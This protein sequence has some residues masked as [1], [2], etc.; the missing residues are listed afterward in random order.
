MALPTGGNKPGEQADNQRNNQR[1]QGPQNNQPEDHYIQDNSASGSRDSGRDF[2]DFSN[3]FMNFEDDEDYGTLPNNQNQGQKIV[4]PSGPSGLPILPQVNQPTDSQ[5]KYDGTHNGTV[6]NR[7]DDEEVFHPVSQNEENSY[8]DYNNSNGFQD[9]SQYN[10]SSRSDYQNAV[11]QSGGDALPTSQ[12]R[13]RFNRPNNDPNAQIREQWNSPIQPVEPLRESS[14]SPIE[15]EEINFVNKKQKKLLPFGGSKSDKEKNQKYRKTKKNDNTSL[16]DSRIDRRTKAK[17]IRNLILIFCLLAVC[18]G[19]YNAFRPPKGVTQTDVDA[20]IS[21]ALVDSTFP[22][23]R[24]KAFAEDFMAA[25]LSISPGA[26]ASG[27]DPILNYYYTGSLSNDAAQSTTQLKQV[28]GNF[29]QTV[30]VPPKVFKVVPVEQN[31]A[32]FE[33]GAVVQSSNGQQTPDGTT[34]QKWVFYSVNVYYNPKADSL[35]VT[36]DS[37]ILIPNFKTGVSVDI[38]E[39]KLPGTGTEDQALKSEISPTINAFMEEFGKSSPDSHAGLD[40]YLIKGAK[41]GAEL[42]KG[43][44]G[45][46]VLAGAPG[47]AV[48][49][50]AYRLTE[51]STTEAA[52]DVNVKWQDASSVQGAGVVYQS[53][54]YVV[55]EKQPNGQWLV[56][57]MTPKHYLKAPKN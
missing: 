16:V 12:T 47:D 25:Y 51:K 2:E 48:Q 36:K 43:L 14:N 15:S 46:F 31:S 55:M 30:V 57:T 40:Q 24:G 20:A 39:E 52:L 18:F 6:N 54:Y 3:E 13:S 5:Q 44:D 8:D 32:S 28:D 56:S 35:A 19:L 49:F 42:V 33:I 9:N 4:S 17:I 11:P 45:K 23:D 21:Q 27:V 26:A 41:S 1:R 50:T 7:Y 34:T 22:M 29:T 10:E 37:P 53:R 38:P